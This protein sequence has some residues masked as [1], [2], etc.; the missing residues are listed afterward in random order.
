MQMVSVGIVGQ[1]PELRLVYSY[2]LVIGDYFIC[3]MEAFSIPNCEATTVTCVLTD[4]V[5]YIF[6]PP[7]Q[8]HSDLGKQLKSEVVA[9]MCKLPG[10]C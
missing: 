3:R 1:F 4:E 10:I 5:F 2:I 9:N 7:E 6:F 8:L